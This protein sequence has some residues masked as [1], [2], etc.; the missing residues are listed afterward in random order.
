ML[1]RFHQLQGRFDDAALPLA[2]T[3]EAQRPA[4]QIGRSHQA[5]RGHGLETGLKGADGHNYRR[6]AGFLKYSAQV[7]H[8]HVTN[9]SDGHQEHCVDLLLP[10]DFNPPWRD[11]FDQRRLGAGADKRVGHQR[12]IADRTLAL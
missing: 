7:S 3:G 4:H 11:P 8:G 10:E 6:D 2:I 12:Q 5:R 9:R 1:S